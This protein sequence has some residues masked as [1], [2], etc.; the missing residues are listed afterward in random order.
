MNFNQ[1]RFNMVEQQ[2]HPWQ[3]FD[4]KILNLL[5]QFKREDFVPEQYH[6]LAFADIEIPLPGIQ[7][8]LCPRVEA[9][10]LQELAIDKLDKILEIGSGSAYI[11]ALL[12]KLGNFVYSI[13]INESNKQFALNN[14][15]KNGIKNVSLSLGNGIHGLAAKAPF[16]KI[17]IGGSLKSIPEELKQQ[18]APGGILVGIIGQAPLMHAVRIKKIDENN[19]IE[20]KIFETY[21]EPL[22]AAPLAAKTKSNLI[23]HNGYN[24]LFKF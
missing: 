7:K 8:M 12:A 21:V 1:A 13:E 16:N 10:L 18:L 19:Y 6:N 5:L 11:T 20:T 14:L 4:S 17:L 15:T 2:I 23:H 9:R 22:V 24:N 3:V